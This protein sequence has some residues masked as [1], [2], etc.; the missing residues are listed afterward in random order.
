MTENRFPDQQQVET[1]CLIGQGE[2]CCRYLTMAPTGWS[3]EKLSDAGRLL[4]IRAAA[5]QMTARGDNCVGL[6]SR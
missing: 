1:V 6:D 5:G 2:K 3:C 4:D